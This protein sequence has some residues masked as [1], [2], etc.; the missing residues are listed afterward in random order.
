MIREKGGYAEKD[1]RNRDYDKNDGRR[2]QHG[3]GRG[4]QRSNH[5]ESVAEHES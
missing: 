3:S 1:D 4:H 2:E 5:N